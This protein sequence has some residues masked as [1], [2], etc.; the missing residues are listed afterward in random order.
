MMFH[1]PLK[2]KYSALS[3]LK[4]AKRKVVDHRSLSL[5]LSLSISNFEAIGRF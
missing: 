5:S 1:W 3:R 2:G 4:E